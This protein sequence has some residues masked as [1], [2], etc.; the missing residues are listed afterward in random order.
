MDILPLLVLVRGHFWYF[1]MSAGKINQT[2]WPAIKNTCKKCMKR[3]VK[4][5][6]EVTLTLLNSFKKTE[7]NTFIRRTKARILFV[8]DWC[9]ICCLL[10]PINYILT[11]WCK[12]YMPHVAGYTTLQMILFFKHT[13]VFPHAWLSLFSFSPVWAVNNCHKCGERKKGGNNF[14]VVSHVENI[15][16]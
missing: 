11:Y 8:M 1:L 15:V 2:Y 3:V 6:K 4:D 13:R 10:I 16:K 12:T 9:T 5:N 7:E 14:W